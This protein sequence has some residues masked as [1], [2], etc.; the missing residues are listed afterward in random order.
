MF[1]A[2]KK[3]I[4]ESVKDYTSRKFD[5]LLDKV[6]IFD[7]LK[8]LFNSGVLTQI[9]IPSEMLEVV[10]TLTLESRN[11]ETIYRYILA[12]SIFNG[13]LVG[14]PG[15]LG[16]GVLISQ[17][18][19]LVMAYQIGRMTG[20]FAADQVFTPT[21]L[22]KM[23]SG[24]GI[25]ALAVTQVFGLALNAVFNVI[26]NTLPAVVP[27]SFIAVTVT[28]LFYGMLI[29]LVFSE[30]VD[31]DKNKLSVLDVGRLAK[32]S[33]EYTKNIGSELFRLFKDDAP[34][35]IA[36][37]R[38]SVGDAWR[39][40]T[41]DRSLVRGDLFLSACLVSLLTKNAEGLTGP[42]SQHYLDAWRMANP[43]KLGPNA[44]FDDI[45]DL[46]NSYD[47][48]QLSYV[49]QGVT[50]KF[51]EILEVEAENYDQDG[52]SA[53]ISSTQN[54]PGFDAVFV[55]EDGSKAIEVNF[56]LT[57][58]TAYIESHLARY[59]DIPVV[60]PPEVA[61]KIDHPLVWG[62][63]F[64]YD[65]IY[66]ISEEN[67]EDVLEASASQYIYLGG[68]AGAGVMQL[69]VSIAPF[70]SAF[71]RQKIT[72]EQLREVFLRFL[73]EVS[74]RAANRMV[75]LAALGPVYAMALTAKIA[76]LMI[77]E[78][79]VSDFADVDLDDRT[80]RD[81]PENGT[82]RYTRRDII[83]LFWPRGDGSQP[84]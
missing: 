69:C 35:L 70:L 24:A 34:K 83:T 30:L 60:A 48:D 25:A 54:N 42:F 14:L 56:K 3:I 79:S 9:L 58:S 19:E 77:G 63:E 1:D 74:T 7:P 33:F 72:S 47:S 36:S 71:A 15:T 81:K 64:S 50:A 38:Q 16:W 80:N 75:M 41:N 57:E 28:T 18:V 49:H 51:Y 73:P 84:N 65:E 68:V 22:V 39:G 46:A 67:F 53:E 27:A 23:L 21:G 10:K 12:V 61:E 17:A 45:C 6:R 59:P 2:L 78:R 52:W 66:E 11:Q 4:P 20:L 29:Y 26:G 5:A 43:T 82:K 76:L 55:N 13:I 40:I 62:G 31:S 8:R 37:L 44:S 32:K